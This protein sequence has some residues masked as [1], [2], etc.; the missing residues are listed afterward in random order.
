MDVKILKS[1]DGITIINEYIKDIKG[2]SMRLSFMAGGFNDPIGKAGLAHFCEHALLG[3]S[4]SRYER[5]EKS[6]KIREF[7]YINGST[8]GYT[9][10]LW[11]EET[12]DKFEKALDLITEAFTGIQY[13][14]ENYNSEYKII[15][16]EIKTRTKTNSGLL[17]YISSKQLAKSK[18]IRNKEYSFAGSVESL[19]KIK[20]KD[21]ENFINTY[22]TKK[23][24]IIGVV[25][26]IKPNETKHLVEKYVSPRLKEGEKL[27]FSRLDNLGDRA[28]TYIYETSFEKGKALISIDY[29]IEKLPR[30]KY[31]DRR[32][33]ALNAVINSMLYDVM[34]TY[35]RQNKELC[36][37]CSSNFYQYIDTTMLSTAI[38]C[39]EE[40]LQK[41]IDAYPEFIQN[42]SSSFTKELF[43]KK[44]EKL[45]SSINFDL[46]PIERK[47]SSNLRSY[48]NFGDIK[49]KEE[50]D[51]YHKLYA[52]FTYEEVLERLNKLKGVKPTI[53]II[54]D[55]KQYD[56][57]NYKDY[58]K[59]VVVKK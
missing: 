57:F 37:S 36:Y 54:S 40:N 15:N 35:F 21:L 14:P 13:T 47:V 45:L 51:F 6:R 38:F 27:G 9:V 23:N 56:D 24:L 58:C 31:F 26:N 41:V 10:D 59:K 2:I 55:D 12:K 50:Y 33:S 18:E 25:G 43:E 4:T 3:F 19:D 28:P 53:I 49:G 48:N 16:D 34:F 39:Q 5:N 7:Q 42:L 22:F 32:T 11:I 52:T 1:K 20:L 29:A 30:E 8:T 17:T 46:E 44:K